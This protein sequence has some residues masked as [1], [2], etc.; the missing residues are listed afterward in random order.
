MKKIIVLVFLMVVVSTPTFSQCER[1]SSYEMENMSHA[2]LSQLK[3]RYYR[4]YINRIGRWNMGE[5][6][7]KKHREEEI[8]DKCKEEYDKMMEFSERKEKERKQKE[9]GEELLRKEY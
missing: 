3:I 9:K 7:W 8:K 6:E 5:S 2:E 4:E 1:I